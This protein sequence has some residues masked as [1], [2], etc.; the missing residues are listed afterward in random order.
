MVLYQSLIALVTILYFLV[1]IYIS[2]PYSHKYT[3][4]LDSN[5]ISGDDPLPHPAVHRLD[6]QMLDWDTKLEP[7]PLKVLWSIISHVAWCFKKLKA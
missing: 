4:H 3:M 7:P 1:S 2:V 6:L 5:Y